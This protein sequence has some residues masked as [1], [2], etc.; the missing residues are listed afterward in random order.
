MLIHGNYLSMTS[1]ACFIVVKKC[2]SVWIHRVLVKIQWNIIIKESHFNSHFNMEGVTD[3]DCWHTKRICK[4]IETKYSGEYY[5]LYGQS[6]ALLLADVLTTFGIVY[7]NIWARSCSFF[8]YTRI[9]MISSLWRKIISIDWYWLKLMVETSITDE[10]CL[11]IHRYVK[12]N[13]KYM[14]DYN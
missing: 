8:F 6:D 3:S 2:L 4:D 1:K 11:A 9:S 10:I 12:A 13:N 5:D 7:C 14:K